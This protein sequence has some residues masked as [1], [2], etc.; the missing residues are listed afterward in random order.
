LTKNWSESIAF[1]PK[2]VF[3]IAQDNDPRFRMKREKIF[4]LF[5]S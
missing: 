2:A 1:T 3:M 5:D 4:I